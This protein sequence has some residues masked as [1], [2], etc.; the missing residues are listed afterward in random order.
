VKVGVLLT[1]ISHQFNN[2]VGLGLWN[3]FNPATF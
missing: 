2:G 1:G 3:L